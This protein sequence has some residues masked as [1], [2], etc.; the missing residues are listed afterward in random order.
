MILLSGRPCP[1]DPKKRMILGANRL[2][3]VP[4]L[5]L[6]RVKNDSCLV[7]NSFKEAITVNQ[8]VQNLFI[9]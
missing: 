5:R 4:R 1:V 8:L 3:G 2:L 9:S 6:L 7:P